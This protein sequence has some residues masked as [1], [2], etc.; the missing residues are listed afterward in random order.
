MNEHKKTT[1]TAVEDLNIT[2]DEAKEVKGGAIVDYFLKVEGI[3]G[4]S[5][6]TRPRTP[7]VSDIAVTKSIDVSR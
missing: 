3:D 5:A 2:E 1:Q 6:S 4:E 7:S